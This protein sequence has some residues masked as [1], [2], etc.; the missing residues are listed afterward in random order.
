[1]MSEIYITDYGI[2]LSKKS[3]RLVV[4][5][6]GQITMEVPFRDLTQVTIASN[7]VSLS[8]NVIRECVE[9]GVQINFL[10]SS[11]KPYAKL[12]SPHLTGTVTTRREQIMA[13]F[14]KRGLYLAK[15][16]IE[17]KLKN[18][19]NLIKY[20]AKYR[21]RSNAALYKSLYVTVSHLENACLELNGIEGVNIDEARGL[22]LSIEG[23]AAQHYWKAVEML[24]DEQVEFNGRGHRGATDPVNAALNYG[25]G[26]LYSQVW[27]AVTLAGLEPFA[28][29]LHT[30]RPGKPSLVL[31]LIEEFRPC[32]VDRAIISLFTKG[33][34]IEIEEEKINQTS[35]RNI[36]YRVLE[37]LDSKENYDGKKYKLRTIIQIQSRR[38]ATNLRDKVKYKPYIMGW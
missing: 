29:Y 18:Q 7:G 24:L 34:T 19:M 1:M 6:K 8:T 26:I 5:E 37:G 36:A 30:D 31:D 35:R 28:G 3:E 14:D 25:Y 21:R 12:T 9:Y 16:F 20:F 23:R 10:T 4:K 13:Y 15:C 33:G 11:G 2:T 32:V 22:I 27:G 17:G 38:L